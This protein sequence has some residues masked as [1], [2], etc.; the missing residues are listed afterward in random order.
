M[1]FAGRDVTMDISRNWNKK[2]GKEQI[3]LHIQYVDNPN[4]KPCHINV[5]FNKHAFEADLEDL[6]KKLQGLFPRG[7]DEGGEK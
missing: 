5:L 7:Y 6:M 1:K 2:Y 3:Q 4:A